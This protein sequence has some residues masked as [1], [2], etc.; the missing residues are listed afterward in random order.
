M[1]TSD[2]KIIRERLLEGD[3]IG[4]PT[5]T[6]YGLAANVFNSSA[7]KRIFETKQRPT[8]NPL[9]VHVASISQ[10]RALVKKF[11]EKALLLAKEFWP[12]PM[13]LILP[14]SQTVSDLVTANHTR[15][16]I[17]IPSHPLT[18]Q[19]LNH[20]DFPLVAPSA[21]PFNRISPTTAEHVESYFPSIYTLDGGPCQSG[22]ESTILGFEDDEVVLLRHGAIPIEAIEGVVGRI[23]NRTHSSHEGALPGQ[24]KKH[25]SPN[26]ELIVTY[27][28]L[29]MLSAVKNKRVAIVWFQA[30]QIESID[31]EVNKVLSPTGDLAE[32]AQQ[33][34]SV[35]HEL[36]QMGIEMIIVERLPAQG[37]GLTVNDRLDRAAAK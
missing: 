15:V 34:F 6:V 13:T 19:L 21:N 12:G 37:L 25:Y 5:E 14:K 30:I 8:T 26:C 33:I 18:L 2:I 11:P 28:P 24:H 3:V 1:I 7:V 36:D 20:L 29:F 32:A 9:I 35:L 17:R 31:V 4:L 23:L 10:A 27:E 16:A 22:V